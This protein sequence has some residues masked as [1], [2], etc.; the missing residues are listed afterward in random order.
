MTKE[1]ECTTVRSCCYGKGKDNP[2]TYET[3][4]SRHTA[5]TATFTFKDA[6]CVDFGIET[7]VTPNDAGR[8]F[9]FDFNPTNI[10]KDFDKP[11]IVPPPCCQPAR[12][13]Q[14]ASIVKEEWYEECNE[15]PEFKQR[16]AIGTTT[17]T[18]LNWR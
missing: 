2:K 3:L 15:E 10:C 17:T 14:W 11:M 1:G 12:C 7:G 6:T 18:T 9:L 4:Q 5:R 16:P 13:K 8:N